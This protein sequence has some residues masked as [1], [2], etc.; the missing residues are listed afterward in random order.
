MGS[1]SM[2][3]KQWMMHEYERRKKII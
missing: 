1:I 3:Q 2:I